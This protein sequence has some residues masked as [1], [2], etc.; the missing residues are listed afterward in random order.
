MTYSPIV[1]V[2]HTHFIIIGD[3]WEKCS[4]ATLSPVYISY[5][6]TR[7]CLCD[8]A[9]CCITQKN[10][11]SG[12]LEWKILYSAWTRSNGLPWGLDWRGLLDERVNYEVYCPILKKSSSTWMTEKIQRPG[13]EMMAFSTLSALPCK[14]RSFPE[15]FRLNWY[16]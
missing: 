2:L 8:C 1:F 7:K 14:W 3:R 11:S 16:L 12:S 10:I 4:F 13:V 6:C 9:C 15:C 5:H